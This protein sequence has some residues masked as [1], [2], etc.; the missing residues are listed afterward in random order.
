[1]N[2]KPSL[3]IL[4][5][6]LTLN[7]S[8]QAE[9]KRDPV[10]AVVLAGGG[11]LGFAHVG[12]L[13]VLEEEGIRPD[14]VIG[15]SIGSIIG[16]L[17][18]AGYS[19]VELEEIIRKTDWKNTLLDSFDRRE[20]S[21]NRKKNESNFLLSIGLD[22]NEDID[23]AGF[24]QGQH[25]ME[26][27]DDLLSPRITETDFDSLPIPFRAVGADLLTGEKVV[28]DGGDL[29]TAIRASMAVPGIFTPVNYRGRYVIDGGWVEN[30]PTMVARDLGA[31]IVIAV[32]LFSMTDDIAKLSTL[33]GLSAQADQIRTMD[34]NVASAEAADLIISPDLTGYNMADFEKGGPLMELGYAA[35]D[36]RRR[37][38]RDLATAIPSSSRPVERETGDPVIGIRGISVEGVNDGETITRIRT[39][40]ENEMGYSPRSSEL[41]RQVY[42][43]YDS[44]DYSHVWYRLLPAP[45]GRYDL[46][47][48]APIRR[49]HKDSLSAAL[50]FGTYLNESRI[51]DFHLKVAYRNWFG[52]EMSNSAFLELGISEYPSMTGGIGYAP[53]WGEGLLALR[54]GVL[55]QTH[56]FYEDDSLDSQ[57]I[58]GK[59]GGSLF[60]DQAL[61]RRFELS[62]GAYG[63]HN[64]TDRKLGSDSYPEE[65]WGRY[66]AK[67]IVNIDTLDRVLSPD[68]GIKALLMNDVSSDD[69]GELSSL[70]VTAGEIFIPVIPGDRGSLFARAEYQSL[71][72]GDLKPLELPA[73]GEAFPVYGYYPQELRAENAALGGL[74]MRIRIASLP[75]SLGNDIY[76][77]LA[78]NNAYLWNNEDVNDQDYDFFYGGSLSLLLNTHLGVLEAG[79]NLNGEGRWTLFVGI[80]SSTTFYDDIYY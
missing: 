18:C 40:L 60:Y 9:E 49:K 21:F 58:L 37:E 13:Q 72:L 56:F 2:I 31:D 34:R 74:G 6:I 30:L 27:L 24:S 44:G 15:T 57:Y 8:L 46:I 67:A 38:I 33:V 16:G 45:D 43:L 79:L 7:L 39:T 41:R 48:D 1:M 35:A 20:L 80:S 68:K 11:A 25:V 69:S 65:D 4:M 78:G 63:R 62:L 5:L 36:T 3:I 51:S 47:I 52:R 59:L 77:Q 75:Y 42:K 71:V 64:W 73:L 14:Y 29:K 70:V 28:Y 19:H 10:V 76:L 26:L 53:S 54:G 12:A 23:A 50:D 32:S 61:F 55:Q 22:K 66:G 17:Y